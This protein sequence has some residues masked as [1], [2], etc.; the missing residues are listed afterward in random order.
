MYKKNSKKD[1]LFIGFESVN[2]N[3]TTLIWNGIPVPRYQI[4]DYGRIWDNRDNRYLGYSI[5]EDG[6]FMVSL[7]INDVIKYKNLEFI[8]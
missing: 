7:Y 8:D 4:S 6:Y 1:D 5:D 3:W 2:E